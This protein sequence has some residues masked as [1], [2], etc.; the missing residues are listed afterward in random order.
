[1]DAAVDALLSDEIQI[2][3][4]SNVVLQ[5][6]NGLFDSLKWRSMKKLKKKWRRCCISSAD[7]V[8]ES[9]F[10]SGFQQN[11]QRPCCCVVQLVKDI[12][13][14]KVKRDYSDTG[15]FEYLWKYNHGL[16]E[17]T[18][19]FAKIGNW[20]RRMFFLRDH[21][22]GRMLSYIS[23]KE[24]GSLHVCAL[25]SQKGRINTVEKLDT[26]Q[27][28]ALSAEQTKQTR[29]NLQDYDIAVIFEDPRGNTAEDYADDVPTQLCPVV[30]EWVDSKRETHRVVVATDKSAHAHIWID[31]MSTGKQLPN[32]IKDDVSKGTWD[33]AVSSKFKGVEDLL[34]A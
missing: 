22:S 3:P 10:R 15:Y 33:N 19:E 29:R 6:E 16:P 20:R 9:S 18:E 13:A 24:S 30:I 23:E 28:T 4:H 26:V 14:K 1:V 5:Q 12:F 21:S 11:S 17:T 31:Y 32:R 8:K 2:T 7:K 27:L 34:T 25:L